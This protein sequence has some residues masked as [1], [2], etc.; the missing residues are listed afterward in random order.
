MLPG[1]DGQREREADLLKAV[2]LVGRTNPPTGNDG[3]GL[4]SVGHTAARKP[5]AAGTY[6]NRSQSWC[7]RQ[8]RLDYPTYLISLLRTVAG[9]SDG[10]LS[11]NLLISPGH[12]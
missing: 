8:P 7:K 5:A 12:I 11:V 3:T 2:S 1:R 6:L 10:K 9:G 4:R